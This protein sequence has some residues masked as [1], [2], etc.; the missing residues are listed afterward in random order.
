M[1]NYVL[2]ANGDPRPEP[3]LLTWAR[4]FETADRQVALDLI[5]EVRISTVFLGIDHNYYVDSPPILFE[6]MI[7]G[8]R[9]NEWEER[10]ATRAEALAGHNRVLALVEETPRLTG[11]AP[12][13]WDPS[14]IASIKRRD[15]P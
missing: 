8:G 9:F 4:W 10:Y 11:D 5:G 1:R 2:D 7:F 13:A 12:E 14:A 3:D 6:T 15:E